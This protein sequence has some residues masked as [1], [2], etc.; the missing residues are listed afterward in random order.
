MPLLV[1]SVVQPLNLLNNLLYSCTH[2]L[3]WD[4][5]FKF[6]GKWTISHPN[7]IN[8]FFMNIGGSV[9]ISVCL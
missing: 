7:F 8:F 1:N 3:N 5:E 6:I 4:I 9:I 2:S